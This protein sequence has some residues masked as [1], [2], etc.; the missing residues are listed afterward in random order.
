MSSPDLSLKLLQALN[1]RDQKT[2]SE[3]AKD[4]SVKEWIDNRADVKQIENSNVQFSD[5]IKDIT[6]LGFASRFSDTRTVQQLVEAGADVTATDSLGN[7]PLHWAI[8]SEV[9]AKQIVEYLLSCD[10]SLVGARNKYNDTPLHRAACS[11]VTIGAKY[12]PLLSRWL[13]C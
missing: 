7:T 3:C 5:H 6:C 12:H 11:S 13:R 10:V 9:K 2:V 8:G 1:D 4:K